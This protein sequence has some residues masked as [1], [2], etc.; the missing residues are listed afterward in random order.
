MIEPVH[1]QGVKLLPVSIEDALREIITYIPLKKGDFFCFANVHL[2]MECNNDPTLKMVL[3]QSTANFPDG[4]A[5]AWA[6]K[7]LGNKFRGRVRGTDCMLRLCSY[8]SENNLKVFLYGN[9]EQVLVALKQKLHTL[10][11]AIK[12]IGLISPPFRELTE[13]E[14]EIMVSKI[15]EANPDILFVS[16]GA[17][18]QEQWM[19]E[20]KERIKAIQLGVGAAFNFITGRVKQAPKWMQ[21]TGLEW[22]YRLPQQPAKTMSRMLLLPEFILRT[23]I[24]LFK[25]K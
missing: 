19:A 6:L 14:D 17:P 24:Q 3:N 16:L 2:I 12:I 22:L 4:M 8:A 7:L 10:F 20:H 23:F 5:V 11:P 18:K 1:L 21:K 9:T 13:E 15:N 25:A